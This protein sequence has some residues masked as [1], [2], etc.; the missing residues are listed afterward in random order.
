MYEIFPN[1]YLYFENVETGTP[2]KLFGTIF[3]SKKCVTNVLNVINHSMKTEQGY[4]FLWRGLLKNR[5][6]D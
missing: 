3:Q 1:V 2:M 6:K 5:E 4:P